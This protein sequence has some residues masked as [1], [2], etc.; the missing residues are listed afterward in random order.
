MHHQLRN[1][2]ET[3]GI[4]VPRDTEELQDVRVR[5]RTPENN[6]P[7]ESLERMIEYHLNLAE[8]THLPDLFHIV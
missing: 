6:F 5:Q 3:V 4:C 1:G 2:G 7:I 8:A